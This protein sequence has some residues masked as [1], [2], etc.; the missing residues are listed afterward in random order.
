MSYYYLL[1]LES[2]SQYDNLEAYNSVGD[3]SSDNTVQENCKPL[4]IVFS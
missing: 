2:E 4:V 3:I 1:D